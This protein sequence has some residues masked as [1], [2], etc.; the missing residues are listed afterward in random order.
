MTLDLYVDGTWSASTSAERIDVVN[1]TTEERI[2]DVPAGAAADVDV[3]VAAARRALE[4]WSQT[5]PHTRAEFVSRLADELER[6]QEEITDIVVAEVG[7]PRR[8]ARWAQVGLGIVDLREAVTAARDFPWEE[9]LRNSLIVREP[10][11]VIGCITPWNY[12]LHQITAKIG[13]A[14]VTGCTVVVKASEVA[15]FTAHALAEAVDAAG[16]PAGVFNLVHGYGPIVGEAIAIHPDIDMVSF[17][18]SNS[19]GK[20][21]LELAAGT[22]KRVS[23]EL[24]GKSAAV[25]LDDLSDEE[26]GKAV[27]H[28]VRACYMNG[29]QSCSAQTRLVVPRSRLA[30]AEK[31]AAKAA[32]AYAPGDPADGD[33]KLGPMVTA[34]QR[35]RVL[36][37]IRAG[38]KEGA[39]LV[40]G[41]VDAPAR[42]GFFVEPTVFSEV[43]PDS[44]IAQEEIFG[45]VLS[46]IAYDTPEQ[47][48]EIANGT[49]F[50]IAGAVWSGDPERA[51]SV[52]RRMR[53]TQIE[54]NGGKFN[55][56]APFGGF[57]QSGLG[58]EGGAFGLEEFVEIKSLQL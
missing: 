12:P 57:K 20:R 18:G 21:V 49:I 33:T 27:P 24:G 45:P 34:S 14:L 6:R 54:V 3:A 53:A 7:T 13:A 31:L 26:F 43:D 40:A 17:T 4:Q 8:V 30:E 25:L 16:V 35:E 11:G 58:R 9:Q 51:K 10:V 28:T 42:T 48:I 46:I 55:G 37:Y 39:K 15:P 52:A 50:G 29:G 23:V 38:V 56:A 5:A 41:S 47:A 22:V 44:T 36:D 2:G 1:P 19:V 32:A